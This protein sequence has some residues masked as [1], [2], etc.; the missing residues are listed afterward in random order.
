MAEAEER[1]TA[2]DALEQHR[3]QEL[4]HWKLVHEQDERQLHALRE[5]VERIARLLLDEAEPAPPAN[6]AA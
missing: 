2:S 1:R 4:R 5:E 3:A 6:Q